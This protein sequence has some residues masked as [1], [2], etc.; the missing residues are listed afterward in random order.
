MEA[1]VENAQTRYTKK[2]AKFGLKN[3]IECPDFKLKCPELIVTN[4]C[5]APLADSRSRYQTAPG[6][7]NYAAVEAK[8]VWLNPLNAVSSSVV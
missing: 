8:F 3:C 1:S 7:E 6:R 5:N 4:D 2:T